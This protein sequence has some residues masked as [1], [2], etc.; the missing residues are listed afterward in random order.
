MSPVKS[1]QENIKEIKVEYQCD[2]CDKTYTLKASYKSHMRNKHKD[3]NQADK[4]KRT[5]KHAKTKEFERVVSVNNVNKILEEILLTI[6]YNDKSN[7]KQAENEEP[8][9]NIENSSKNNDQPDATK[10]EDVEHNLP[11][12]KSSVDP[13]GDWLTHTNTDLGLMLESAQ[14]TLALEECDECGYSLEF[15]E[16][17]NEHKK[18]EHPGQPKKVCATCGEF[19]NT[20]TDLNEHSLTKHTPPFSNNTTCKECIRLKQVE[21]FKN[22]VIE[23]KDDTIKQLGNA[24]R[25]MTAKKEA[26][27][28]TLGELKKEVEKEQKTVNKPKSNVVNGSSKDVKKYNCNKCR[29]TSNT[30]YG[31]Y[32]HTK[33][34]HTN[35][36]KCHI[37]P[38]SFLFKPTL[39][40]HMKQEHN[41]KLVKPPNKGEGDVNNRE[42]GKDHNKGCEECKMKEEVLRHK[43]KE[44]DKKDNEQSKT[45]TDLENLHRKHEAMKMKYNNVL[46]SLGDKKKLFAENTILRTEA[47]ESSDK[48][49]KVVKENLVLK[50]GNTVMKKI[51]DED[52]AMKENLEFHNKTAEMSQEVREHNRPLIKC[53]KC[54]YTTKINKYFEGHMKAHQQLPKN[55][56]NCEKMFKSDK[57]L[58]D[59]VK[60]SHKMEGE[61]F[62]CNKCNNVFT[63]HNALKQHAQSKHE[64]SARVPVGHQAWAKEQNALQ[65]QTNLNCTTCPAIFRTEHDLQVHT[66]THKNAFTISCNHCDE[67]F[68]VKNDLNHHIRTAHRGFTTIQKPCRYFNKGWCEKGEMCSFSHAMDNNLWPQREQGQQ[69]RTCTRGPGCTFLARGTCFYYHPSAGARME[70]RQGQ[71][72]Q[73]HKKLCHFQERCWHQETCRYT[74]EDFSLSEEF[75]ENY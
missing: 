3:E 29:F 41:V 66:R 63:T 70:Q 13:N 35:K 11:L 19:F 39:K 2:L 52:E 51:M 73:M 44:L 25:E 26:L 20:T 36:Y 8:P 42:G 67:M 31:Y 34:K 21:G 62:Q 18:V 56:P 37:C 5:T 49:Q 59:H 64:A 61:K 50:E 74:H 53:N 23:K 6:N 27:E 57:E 71:K 65:E 33:Q 30:I 28:E 14:A 22:V 1:S 10:E 15:A 12:Q 40:V 9:K 45:K 32:N 69:A 24:L 72:Q 16:N 58:Q 38:Q 43:E 68:E 75:L 17:L 46:K 47:K 60:V 4:N 55:C 54:A 7:N 48:L